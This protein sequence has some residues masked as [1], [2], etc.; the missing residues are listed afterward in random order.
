MSKRW[1]SQRVLEQLVQA[2]RSEPLP[3]I[4]FDQLQNAVR[5]A[6][7]GRS[8]AP[9]RPVL[10]WRWASAAAAAVAFF[11]GGWF[12]HAHH[13]AAP[14]SANPVVVQPLDGRALL[15]G[16][17]LDAE[18]EPLVV[19]HPGVA[20]WTLA[21]QGIARITSKGDHL[22]LQL[23]T[24]RIDADVIPS[25]QLETFAVEAAGLRVAVHGTV[26]SVERVGEFVDVAVSNG[27]VVVGRAGQS[28]PTKGTLLSA[29]L[30]ERFSI[31]QSADS[32]LAPPREQPP[33]GPV[34]ARSKALT[35]VPSASPTSGPAE[36]VSAH[37]EAPLL[38]RPAR[39][40]LE[41]ALDAVRA[42]AAR[43]FAQAK[44]TETARDSHVTVRVETQLSIVIAPNGKID[45]ASFAPPIP[46]P[47]LDCTRREIGDFAAP[48]TKLGGLASRPIMLVR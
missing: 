35:P 25:R 28:G 4:D 18:R 46:E 37:V 47:I 27:T 16:Q 19:N 48:P 1:R 17:E 9:P 39:V 14:N 26:F 10:N 21:P 6:W 12:G 43:C 15:V 31:H 36:Q 24:G 41:S 45:E 5:K 2:T 3:G 23:D 38:D 30:H 42:A 22:T 11:I 34:V 29:P 44:E 33:A 13:Q 32:G 8:I 7:I 20:K 40:E